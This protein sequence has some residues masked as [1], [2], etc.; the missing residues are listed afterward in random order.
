MPILKTLG[1]L[2]IYFYYQVEHRSW[3]KSREKYRDFFIFVSTNAHPVPPKNI[4]LQY[5]E[6][7]MT[8]CHFNVKI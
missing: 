6:K 5:C 3:K 7:P 1:G 4:A 8:V 2:N